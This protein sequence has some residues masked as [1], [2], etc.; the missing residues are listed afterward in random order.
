MEQYLRHCIA[1]RPST[2]CWQLADLVFDRGDS[3]GCPPV[4]V[5]RKVVLV[6]RGIEFLEEMTVLIRES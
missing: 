1:S 2:E 4:N 3:S 6:V 5:V